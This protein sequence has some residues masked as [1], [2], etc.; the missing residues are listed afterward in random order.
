MKN[1]KGYI[2][3]EALIISAIVLTA[4]ILIYAQFARLNKSYNESY[5]YNSVNGLYAL[6][7]VAT[8]LDDDGIESIE[9]ALTDYLDITNCSYATDL[10]Y[11]KLLIDG[12]NIKYLLYTS[13]RPTV[14]MSALANNN[15]YDLRL[16]NFI[17]TLS[18]PEDVCSHMLIAEFYDGTYAAIPYNEF[19]CEYE[20][21]VTTYAATSNQTSY[22]ASSHQNCAEYHVS[23]WSG[24]CPSDCHSNCVNYNDGS[25]GWECNKWGCS[26]DYTCPNGGSRSG[27]RC[28]VTS[29]SCNEGDTRENTTCYHYECPKGGTLNGTICSH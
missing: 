18:S 23:G 1:N 20:A 14:I 25:G 5:Y 10:N 17:K 24:S 13:N 7:Q 2:M 28:Y 8:F 12:T 29:Y 21:T 27:D 19:T 11:C 22:A 16:R 3:T 9:N 6:N 15:T 4:L 26:T